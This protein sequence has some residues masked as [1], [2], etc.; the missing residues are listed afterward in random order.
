MLRAPDDLVGNVRSPIG[1]ETHFGFLAST[2]ALPT[3]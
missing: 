3:L 1:P 2:M